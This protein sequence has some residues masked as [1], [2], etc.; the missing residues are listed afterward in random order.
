MLATW[1]VTKLSLSLWSI[2]SC[3]YS[4][5]VFF[6]ECSFWALVGTPCFRR[7]IGPFLSAS[8]VISLF[9]GFWNFLEVVCT[10]LL[11]F[12]ASGRVPLTH[13]LPYASP[14]T[15]A[16]GHM[17]ILVVIVQYVMMTCFLL[18]VPCSFVE[19]TW[20]DCPLATVLYF[21]LSWQL[22][23][24]NWLRLFF[25]AVVLS[26]F[27]ILINFC[28]NSDFMHKSFCWGKTCLQQ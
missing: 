26:V 9:L 17:H 24:F 19:V 1:Q 6:F 23:D 3:Y 14:V 4:W 11:L 8:F 5:I 18:T 22:V 7:L 10:W 13:F 27:L 25:V 15:C 28:Y 20:R 21:L 12:W 16:S 2:F